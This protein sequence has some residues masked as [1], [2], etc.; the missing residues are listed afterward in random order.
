[1]V[2]DWRGRLCGAAARGASHLLRRG[3][4]PKEIFIDADK[5]TLHGLSQFYVKLEEG[6]KTR[7][8]TDLM[9]ILE[10][11]QVVIFVRDKR[12]CHS[13]NR[14]LVESKFPSIELHSDM[15]AEDRCAP[16]P[17]ARRVRTG[18]FLDDGWWGVEHR[19]LP[20]NAEQLDAPSPGAGWPRNCP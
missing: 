20:C 6:Q 13:L 15:D 2:R 8:L 11:N 1:V 3:W 16:S 5:L 10:F 14:I 19:C 18:G 12:R 9:D 7:K 17:R 4:Q